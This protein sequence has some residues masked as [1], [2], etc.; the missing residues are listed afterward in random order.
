MKNIVHQD[1][2]IVHAFETEPEYSLSYPGFET[3][4][5]MVDSNL[6]QGVV[7]NPEGYVYKD[8]QVTPVKS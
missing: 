1:G 4:V 3:V 7:E 8:G 2:K 6:W 5:V